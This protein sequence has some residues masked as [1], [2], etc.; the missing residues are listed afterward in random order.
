MS[1]IKEL[2]ELPED[3]LEVLIEDTSKEIYELKNKLAIN[4]KLEKPHQ[5]R[6]KKER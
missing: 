3:Q 2:R 6:D 4:R 5:L 1:N